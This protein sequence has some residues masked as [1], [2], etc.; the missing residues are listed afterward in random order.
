MRLTDLGNSIRHLHELAS[1]LAK[2][3]DA[4]KTMLCELKRGHNLNRFLDGPGSAGAGPIIKKIAL[5]VFPVPGKCLLYRQ[6]TGVL[7]GAWMDQLL[8]GSC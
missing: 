8:F 7:K 4:E 5:G 1:E 6:Y 3:R 2:Y